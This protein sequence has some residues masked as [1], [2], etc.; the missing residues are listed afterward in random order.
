MKN[1][2]RARA[3]THMPM[4]LLTLLSIIQA[5][6]LE[7]I[8]SHITAQPYLFTLT[9][10][11]LLSWIQVA[12]TLAGVLLIWLIYSTLVMR[13]RWIPS[14]SDTVFPF[15]IGLIE[16]TLIA[17]MGPDTLLW[18]FLTMALLFGI[19]HWA[20]Q[21]ILVAARQDGENAS[22]FDVVPPATLRDFIPTLGICLVFLAFGLGL[23]YSGHQGGFALI[24]LLLAAATVGWQ[25]VLNTR[26]WRQS[27]A[28]DDESP[29]A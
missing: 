19:T 16:F 11:A 20:V 25:L 9:W 15:V 21:W 4:V 10:T 13:F 12:T 29:P 14:T 1:P 5:L 3:K 6:A 8:W 7:L 18:W 26:Y 24:G 17:T 2:M 22:F 23:G 27:M 28:D